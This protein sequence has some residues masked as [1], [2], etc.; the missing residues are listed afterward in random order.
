M[1][2]RLAEN[3]TAAQAE[4]RARVERGAAW[5]DAQAPGWESKVD[6]GRLVMNNCSRCIIGQVFGHFEEFVNLHSE[7]RVRRGWEAEEFGFDVDDQFP[8]AHGYV[9]YEL[10]TEAWTDLLKRRANQ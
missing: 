10:L 6:V 3:D 4:A 9:S 1:T 8:S 5:L 7:G 2:V